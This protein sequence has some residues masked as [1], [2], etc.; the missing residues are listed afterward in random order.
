M[1][2]SL[3]KSERR[4]FLFLFDLLGLNAALLVFISV[5]PDYELNLNLVLKHPVWFIFLSLAWVVV[6]AAFDIYDL[7]VSS[8]LSSIIPG[9]AKTVA[10]AG[11]IFLLVPYISPPLPGR[12][13]ILA[14]F[15]LM[16]GFILAGRFLYILC[17]SPPVFRRRAVIIGTGLRANS[18]AGAIWENA[19]EMY[20]IIG[21]VKEKAEE[22]NCEK[23]FASEE[24]KNN[25][26]GL[27]E[28]KA[29]DCFQE[30]NPSLASDDLISGEQRA[31][32]KINA[33]GV[34]LVGEKIEALE[35][36]NHEPPGSLSILGTLD[37]LK[38]II[39]DYQVDTLILAPESE[40]NGQAFQALTDSLEL[41]VEITPMPVL[42]EELT[43]RVPVEHVGESW[44]V[45]MPLDHPLTRP[46]NRFLK[47]AKDIVLASIGCLIL[48]PLF[49]FIALAIYIESPGP[50]FYKQ[51]RVGKGGKVF[52][53]YKFRSMVPDAE[54]GRPVW[55]KKNDERVTRV[56]KFLRKTHLD[57]FPQ[58]INILK[59]EM[60]AVGPRP[61]RPEFVEELARE[62]PFYR[63]R[64]AVKPGMAGWGLVRQGYGASKE[65]TLVKLQY[66]LYY[67]KHQSLWFDI[68]I[69]IK[70]I[71]DTLTLR[72]R[73]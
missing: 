9:I 10:I 39:N 65:D 22:T 4:F 56:G 2:F 62:I 26:Q 15:I 36:L 51:E 45:A 43:G 14:F 64:H 20:E 16:A 52:K 38:E 8:R 37:S 33:K 49:P 12:R 66:D 23:N 70:T 29:V 69:L 47:R 63:V 58:F 19:P 73:A 42:Y 30:F 71:F 6:G 24:K 68:V 13:F 31:G 41:G 53:A 27:S 28:A 5:R 3:E 11:G 7:K 57:E 1:R 61:E 21:A 25:P 55:A 54:K 72:G 17:F 59:G 67:I 34:P 18:I 60:S 35:K 48:A 50:I 46:L 40:V 44:Q 32:E